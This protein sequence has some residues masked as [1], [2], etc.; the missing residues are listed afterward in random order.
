MC[1]CVPTSG[2]CKLFSMAKFN[3]FFKGKKVHCFISNCLVLDFSSMCVFKLWKH[4][5][6]LS[7]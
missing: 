3:I 5:F 1:L 4:E 7:I 6:M 2:Y